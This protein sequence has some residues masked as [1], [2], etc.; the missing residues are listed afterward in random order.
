[1]WVAEGFFSRGGWV[2]CFG[3][4][5][6]GSDD[7]VV[8]PGRFRRGATSGVGAP[9]VQELTATMARGGFR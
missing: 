3:D 8:A 1:M 2:D 5:G 7:G 9:Y 4:G 6:D